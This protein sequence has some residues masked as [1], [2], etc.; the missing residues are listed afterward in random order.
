MQNSRSAHYS[1]LPG[2]S[3]SAYHASKSAWL[4]DWVDFQA[5]HSELRSK[6]FVGPLVNLTRAAGR[7][8]S[9][10]FLRTADIAECVTAK[11]S[12][13]LSHAGVPVVV[14]NPVGRRGMRGWGGRIRTS[15]WR[16]Q[17]PL[18]YRLATPQSAA[19][20][21]RP[22]ESGRTIVRAPKRR[23]GLDCDFAPSPKGRAA[24]LSELGGNKTVICGCSRA[25]RARVE[26]RASFQTP[27][28]PLPCIATSLRSSRKR[29]PGPRRIRRK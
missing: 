2:Q 16:N 28:R 1:A 10:S 11:R 19:G 25:L 13:D 22:A 12:F 21:E 18:P 3:R 24:A 29:Q 27:R 26:R 15:G 14:R 6:V 20:P 5:Q 23:N 17:N 4:F 8:V 9:D 7:Q